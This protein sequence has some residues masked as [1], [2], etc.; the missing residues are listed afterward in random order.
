MNGK[1]SH[2]HGLEDNIFKMP[3][4][5]EA[6]YGFNQSLSKSQGHFLQKTENSILKFIWNPKDESQR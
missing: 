5:L 2:V 1:T 4:L 6:I 3:I